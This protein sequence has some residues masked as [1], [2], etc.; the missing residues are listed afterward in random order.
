MT[1][2]FKTSDI[3]KNPLFKASIERGKVLMEKILQ[4]EGGCLEEA[5]VA[6]VLSTSRR[7]VREGR[8][9]GAIL[10]LQ[11][12][13]RRYVYPSWQFGSGGLLD[14]IT[15]T[16]LSFED[17][18]PWRRAVFFLSGNG[19]LDGKRPLDEIRNGNLEAVYRAAWAFGHQ[20]GS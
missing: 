9:L 12:N 8:K 16:M 19:I 18:S 2:R 6:Q 15:G 10:A 7:K 5:Q 13:T 4:M 3:Y 20:G 14:G 17:V 11:T 1:E